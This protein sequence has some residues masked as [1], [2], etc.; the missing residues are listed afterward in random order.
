MPIYAAARGK[1]KSFTNDPLMGNTVILEH[2]NGYTTVYGHLSKTTY[3]NGFT[4]VKAGD[5][6]GY[7]G[8]SGKMCFGPHLHFEV[9]DENG[10]SMNPEN[11]INAGVEFKDWARA[12]SLMRVEEDGSIYLLIK[13]GLTKINKDNCWDILSKNT[14][15]ISEND[16]QNLLDLL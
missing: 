7:S 12:R 16:Y 2:E 10:I 8:D 3:Q 11:F 13:G 6:I 4:T 1:W 5:L 9:R 15:G 14:W